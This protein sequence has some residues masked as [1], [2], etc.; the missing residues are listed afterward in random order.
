[1]I[2]IQRCAW[3]I[4]KS[5]SKA[6]ACPLLRIWL[7]YSHKWSFSRYTSCLTICNNTAVLYHAHPSSPQA[8]TSLSHSVSSFSQTD[9]HHIHSVSLFLID[10]SLCDHGRCL[11]H[12]RYLWQSFLRS[13]CQRQLSRWNHRKCATLLSSSHQLC[14]WLLSQGSTRELS[15]RSRT[16]HSPVSADE[17]ESLRSWSTVRRQEQTH[18]GSKARSR[19][20]AVE[21]LSG[22]SRAGSGCRRWHHHLFG[23]GCACHRG[24]RTPDQTNAASGCDHLQTALE[25]EWSKHNGPCWSPC[26]FTFRNMCGLS[27]TLWSSW[28]LIILRSSTHR[29]VLLLTLWCERA[30]WA[31]HLYPSGS[32]ML[33]TVAHWLM[34]ATYFVCETT[35][36][37]AGIVMI[38]RS[39]ACL[40]RS[41]IWRS[42]LIPVNGVKAECALIPQSSPTID[43]RIETDSC[44]VTFSLSFFDLARIRISH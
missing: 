21:A 8:K 33:R 5:S 9:A 14:P 43:R 6:I 7:E 16:R 3:A 44:V 35:R 32:G 17:Q 12:R 39:W 4:D 29:L 42:I 2:H 31:W 10:Q 11:V 13:S 27:E 28:V 23:C 26:S 22:E 37:F 18:L 41:G 36:V 19:I 34:M 30:R 24:C 20:L 38:N 25:G 1:M 40:P 15:H